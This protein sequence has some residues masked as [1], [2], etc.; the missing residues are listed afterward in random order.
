MQANSSCR[1]THLAMK[2][3]LRNFEKLHAHL[4]GEDSEADREQLF[5]AI[6]LSWRILMC[7]FRR[8]RNSTVVWRTLQKTVVGTDIDLQ[9]VAKI[10]PHIDL[11]AEEEFDPEKPENDIVI[12][13]PP[14][15]PAI[16]DPAFHRIRHRVRIPRNEYNWALMASQ[17]PALPF[18]QVQVQIITT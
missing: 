3:S 7:H 18:W 14:G 13:G 10:L 1:V 16:T 17:A 2:T 15:D 6:S 9:P 5:N 11:C 8:C 4:I 12:P